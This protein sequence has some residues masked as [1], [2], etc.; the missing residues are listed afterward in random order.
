MLP[1]RYKTG[2]PFNFFIDGIPLL[3]RHPS[4]R[5]VIDEWLMTKKVR[6]ELIYAM[7]HACT[8]DDADIRMTAAFVL[9]AIKSDKAIEILLDL[10]ADEDKYV[11]A[12]AAWALVYASCEIVLE[13]LT[14]LIAEETYPPAVAFALNSAMNVRIQLLMSED[15]EETS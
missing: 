1:I 4:Y 9:G 5:E 7:I 13:R 3:S 8:E 15:T 6:N 11:R 2:F 14:D 10:T 12:T